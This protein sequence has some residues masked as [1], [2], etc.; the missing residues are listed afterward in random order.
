MIPPG[1]Y[2]G[3]VPAAPVPQSP[4]PP[5]TGRGSSPQRAN[6]VPAHVSASSAAT[7]AVTKMC[8]APPQQ[9]ATVPAA[10]TAVTALSQVSMAPAS[11]PLPS[12]SLSPPNSGPI[13]GRMLTEPLPKNPAPQLS[14]PVQAMRGRRSTLR[15]PQERAR[16]SAESEPPKQVSPNVTTWRVIGT[17]AS[18]QAMGRVPLVAPPSTAQVL[19]AM[20]GSG[21]QSAEEAPRSGYSVRAQVGLA[22]RPGLANGQRSRASSPLGSN[23]ASQSSCSTATTAQPVHSSVDCCR[24]PGTYPIPQ[25]PPTRPCQATGDERGAWAQSVQDA[26]TRQLQAVRNLAQQLD[27]VRE[28]GEARCS[29]ALAAAQAT[30]LAADHCMQRLDEAL[31]AAQAAELA[32]DRCMQ[33]LDEA[34]PTHAPSKPS[35]APRGTSNSSDVLMAGAYRGGGTGS[36]AGSTTVSVVDSPRTEPP[37]ITELDVLVAAHTENI[38]AIK[39]DHQSFREVALTAR[40]MCDRLEDRMRNFEGDNVVSKMA[41]SS[42]KSEVEKQGA[43]LA[44][45]CEAVASLGSAQVGESGGSFGSVAPPMIGASDLEAVKRGQEALAGSFTAHEERQ[46]QTDAAVSE[47][48]AGFEHLVDRLRQMDSQSNSWQATLDG[49]RKTVN[50]HEEFLA[51]ISGGQAGAGQCT[52]Q[53]L[54]GRLAEAHRNRP[55][56]PE[57]EE[58]ASRVSRLE[59]RCE[60]IQASLEAYKNEFADEQARLSS[61]AKSQLSLSSDKMSS[62]EELQKTMVNRLDEVFKRMVGAAAGDSENAHMQ[63]TASAT[64]LGEPKEE[65]SELRTRKF[66]ERMDERVHKLEAL[67][68]LGAAPASEAPRPEDSLVQTKLFTSTKVSSTCGGEGVGL[69]EAGASDVPSE[70]RK[71]K[72]MTT[73]RSDMRKQQLMDLKRDLG[74][75]AALSPVSRPK[76]GSLRSAASTSALGTPMMSP[77]SSGPPTRLSGGIAGSGGSIGGGGGSIPATF[78][79]TAQPCTAP[80]RV[81]LVPN[82][83][84]SSSCANHAVSRS[85]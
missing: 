35:R 4:Q 5:L 73:F 24:T 47:L 70:A 25:S 20:A 37:S 1:S 43:K 18:P 38:Q 41:F 62:V 26:L 8:V 69:L 32:A 53:D 61:W 40:E 45:L 56:A 68:L 30:E 58:I 75:T 63:S 65:A 79:A 17:S 59:S 10:T 6:V 21:A 31:A 9:G 33:R 78:P 50:S 72:D 81:A 55:E 29:E 76:G 13:T 2:H 52:T 83:L 60:Q 42:V 57:P 67:L 7:P 12:R 34:L 39:K 85:P 19:Q 80:S 27:A 66:M 3:H 54:R 14:S 71:E 64:E 16:V 28:Q 77:V 84:H 51:S 74:Q 46:R 15:V 49:M 22:G 44:Q 48:C 11:V 23:C 36:A 82:V